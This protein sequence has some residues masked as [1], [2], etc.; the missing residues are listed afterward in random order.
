[1]GSILSI[2]SNCMR[3]GAH[4]F[5][6]L[7][8]VTEIT[9][10]KFLAYNRPRT[11]PPWVQ[12]PVT[13]VFHCHYWTMDTVHFI[14]QLNR[15]IA[16]VFL[17]IWHFWLAVL[18][19]YFSEASRTEQISRYGKTDYCLCHMFCWFVSF[20][21]LYLS[22]TNALCKMCRDW[23]GYAENELRGPW[24]VVII[25]VLFSQVHLSLAFS[26]YFCCHI[27]FVVK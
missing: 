3:P 17:N 23:L 19:V 4:K 22:S 2:L 20:V 8:S 27:K 6:Y 10:H 26:F 16:L 24:I 11:F 21:W 25:L 15:G 18:N 1:M 14:P 7:V 13:L 12:F 9:R 5:A